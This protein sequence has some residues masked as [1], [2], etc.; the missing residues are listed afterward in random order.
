MLSSLMR[1]ILLDA[2]SSGPPYRVSKGHGHGVTKMMKSLTELERRGL[3]T[4]HPFSVLT[5][6]GIAEAK[7]LHL[8]PVQR[9]ESLFLPPMEGQWRDGHVDLT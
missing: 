3:I 2:I 7:W 4:P 9:D 5:E 8:F 1:Q 6:A